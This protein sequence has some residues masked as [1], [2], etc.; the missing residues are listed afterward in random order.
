MGYLDMILKSNGPFK[1]IPEGYILSNRYQVLSFIKVGGMGAIYKVKDLKTDRILAMKQMLVRFTTNYEKQVVI[2][3]FISEIQIL[4]SLRHP[5]VPRF[6]D[7]FVQG[8]SFFFVMEYIK[9]KDLSRIIKERYPQGAPEEIAIDWIYQLVNALEYLHSLKPPVIH[10]DIKPQNIML[11]EDR[12]I[13]L[14]DFG[15]SRPKTRNFVFG[16]PGYLPPEQ[17]EAGE[18]TPASDIFALGMTAYTILTAKLPNEDYS[19]NVRRELTERGFSKDLVNLLAKATELDPEK[20]FQSASQF[21]EELL[22][23]YPYLK[24][25]Y[26]DIY[27][28]KPQEISRDTYLKI[29]KEEIKE[30]ASQLSYELGTPLTQERILRGIDEELLLKDYL[31]IQFGF[32]VPIYLI[33]TLEDS[34]LEIRMREN[35]LSPRKLGDLPMDISEPQFREKLREILRAFREE[36]E[37][38]NL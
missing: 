24:A 32:F 15:I 35:L 17:L 2:E 25:K 4:K 21:K 10:R 20:R 7:A 27:T 29:L 14:I 22:K 38:H 34:K 13:K 19:T 9:G 36:V 11:E 31:E 8:D 26:S 16:T 18:V 28:P 33:L 5:N 3:N 23:L 30:F 1:P 12:I 37:K 6:F